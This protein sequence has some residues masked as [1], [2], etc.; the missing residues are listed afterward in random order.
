MG[1][2]TN[3][4]TV[5]DKIHKVLNRIYY[6]LHRQERLNYYHKVVKPRN[7]RV[8]KNSKAFGIKTYKKITIIF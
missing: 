7:K 8:P 5:S 3:H 6:K 2:E 4:N 1:N